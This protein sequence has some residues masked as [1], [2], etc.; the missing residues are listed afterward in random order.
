MTCSG[1]LF[2][3]ALDL[4]DFICRGEIAGWTSLIKKSKVQF[5]RIALY[6]AL[7]MVTLA[8]LWSFLLNLFNLSG[9]LPALTLAVPV[10]LAALGSVSI[11]LSHDHQTLEYDE[12]QIRVRTGRKHQDAHDWLEFKECSVINRNGRI[13]VRAYV[14]RGGSHFDID[15]KA[16]GVDP[17]R[18]RDYA[19]ARILRRQQAD[20][21]SDVIS[22][23]E[24]EVHRGR[25]YWVADLNETFRDYQLSGEWLSLIARGTTRPKGFLL[26]RFAAFTLMPNYSV[27]LYAYRLNDSERDP[28]GRILRLLRLIE[29]QRDQKDVKW[30]WL[31]LLGGEPS[32]STSR[33]IE[34]FGNRDVGVGYINMATGKLVVSQNQLGRSLANQM[35]LNRLIVDLRKRRYLP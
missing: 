5:S 14:E 1:C 10:L 7:L 27:C 12:D 11:Y 9:I 22:G 13:K 23:L 2:L 3:H 6:W 31:L 35:R 28:K 21:A 4:E 26:S 8:I 32:N 34:E 25:A 33:F 20:Q 18:L 19:S 16:S 30:S 29:T 24:R 15:S 17:Y